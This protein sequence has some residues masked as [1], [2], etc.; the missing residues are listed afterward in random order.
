M[1]YAH[2]NTID[3]KFIFM[4]L[5]QTGKIHLIMKAK[6]LSNQ[7]SIISFFALI[8]FSC[9]KETTLNNLVSASNSENVTAGTV[10][11]TLDLRPGP[12]DGQDAYVEWKA[13]DAAFA[14]SNYNYVPELPIAAWTV[15]SV[16]IK[17]R[18]YIN[19]T[20]LSAIP[21]N[22]TIISAQLYL[23][24]LPS[25][26]NII[27]G[28]SRYQGSPY[29]YSNRCIITRVESRKKWDESTITWNTQPTFSTLDAV[30]FGPTT[31]QW[32]WDVLCD[33][34]RLVKVMVKKPAFS[35]GFGIQL[36]QENPYRSVIFGSSETEDV[37]NRPRLLVEYSL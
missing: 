1:R 8:L 32:N 15:N 31:S 9:K 2:I 21:T 5:P 23:Y 6:K 18:I 20:G 22:A 16:P 11:Q 24:G 4:F 17:E 26:T 33:V 19:F 10:T 3:K 37:N 14:K 35:G 28:N 34:T 27:T 30:A 36:I 13:D 12:D 25:S 29:P 7:L